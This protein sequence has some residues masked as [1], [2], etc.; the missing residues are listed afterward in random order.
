MLSYGQADQDL[1]LSQDSIIPTS[2]NMR[3]SLFENTYDQLDATDRKLEAAIAN[4]RNDYLL[5]DENEQVKS[6]QQTEFDF[7]QK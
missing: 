5:K 7:A 3:D 1:L 6:K 2:P 4:Y